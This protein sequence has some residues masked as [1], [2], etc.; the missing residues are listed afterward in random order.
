[1]RLF[2]TKKLNLQQLVE[3]L[4]DNPRKILNLEELK[5]EKGAKANLTFFNTDEEWTFDAKNVRSK[6][7]NSP[8]LNTKLTGRALGIFNKGKLVLN[9][10][11]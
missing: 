2:K 10:L 5:I 3:K 8:Y 9:Q 1:M 11:R 6:S 7:K 4:S